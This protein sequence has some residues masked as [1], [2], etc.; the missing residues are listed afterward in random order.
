MT[1][2]RHT[3]NYVYYTERLADP[4]LLDKALVTESGDLA[5]PV[6]GTRRGG[7]TSVVSASEGHQLIR[8]MREQPELFPDPRF[9]Y[10]SRYVIAFG[11]KEP[12]DDEGAG[13]HFGYSDEAIAAFIQKNC[14]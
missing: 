4:A 12:D 7:W 14:T 9:G 2:G 11:A 10:N 8:R 13:R 5:V 1:I 6:G 3:K